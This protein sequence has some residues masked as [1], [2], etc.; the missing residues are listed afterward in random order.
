MWIASLSCNRCSKETIAAIFPQKQVSDFPGQAFQIMIFFFRIIP[1]R[2]WQK[3]LTKCDAVFDNDGVKNP[4]PT[5]GNGGMIN[6][7]DIN[8]FFNNMLS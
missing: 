7:K 6:Y 4:T 8:E 3:S 5:D 2:R 1:S